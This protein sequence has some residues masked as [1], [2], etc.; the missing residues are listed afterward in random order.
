V[1]EIKQS[2]APGSRVLLHR[3]DLLTVRMTLGAPA[4][5][6]AW[7]RTNIGSAA[8]RRQEIIQFAESGRPILARDWHDIPMREAGA[9][10]YSVALPLLEIG[11]F[12]VKAF[13]LPAGQTDPVWPPGENV[14]VKIEPAEY[15]GSCTIYNAFVRQFL[16]PPVPLPPGVAGACAPLEAAGYSVIPPSGTFRNL[17]RQVDFI[18]GKLGF[19]ILLLLPI[20][21]PPTTYARMGHFGSPYAVLDFMDVDPAL[22]EFDRKTTPLDQFR[23]LADAVHARDARLFID[24]PVNHTGWAS[25]LQIHHPHWFVRNEDRSFQSPGAWGV[26]WE[27]LSKLDFRRRDLWQYM[28]EVF[29]YWCRQGVDGFRCDAGYMVPM[30]VWQYIVAKVR[31]EFPETIF[32]LEGLGGPFAAV[33]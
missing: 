7:V 9:N 22:A 15:V 5:G 3:G 33:E 12:E 17:T 14:A 32:L 20:H 30:P 18:V 1:E 19:R 21:P 26:T 31:D 10:E 11:Q 4:A 8:V 29:L 16:A 2:P 13:F 25:W 28:A 23:E 24:I 27:D 6:T